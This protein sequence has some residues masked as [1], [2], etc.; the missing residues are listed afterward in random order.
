MAVK[1]CG[2]YSVTGL[3]CPKCDFIAVVVDGCKI[4]HSLM[5]TSTVTL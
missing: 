1:A 5:P 2:F 4:K 3:T